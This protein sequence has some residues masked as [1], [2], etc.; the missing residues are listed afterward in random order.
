MTALAASGSGCSPAASATLNSNLREVVGAQALHSAIDVASTMPTGT[1]P[2]NGSRWSVLLSS[3]TPSP[4]LSSQPWKGVNNTNVTDT[5]SA[6]LHSCDGT[7]LW[8]LSLGVASETSNTSESSNVVSDSP[9]PSESE[10]CQR[11]GSDLDEFNLLAGYAYLRLH[12]H[13]GTPVR[14]CDKVSASVSSYLLLQASR[15]RFT[16][17]LLVPVPMSKVPVGCS[18]VGN[19]PTMALLQTSSGDIVCDPHIVTFVTAAVMLALQPTS[20]CPGV[21]VGM[22]GDSWLGEPGREWR[23]SGADGVVTCVTNYVR[24]PALLC[25]TVSMA[26]SSSCTTPV[27][28]RSLSCSRI[29]LPGKTLGQFAPCSGCSVHVETANKRRSRHEHNEMVHNVEATGASSS[30]TLNTLIG[31]ITISALAANLSVNESYLS[32]VRTVRITRGKITG[33]DCSELRHSRHSLC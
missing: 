5:G 15:Y 13:D 4:A 19:C 2:T 12:W 21:A 32:A 23:G 30:L 6:A 28:I 24:N 18:Y 1:K 31:S 8:R 33:S 22:L 20:P 26:Y 16:E 7:L 29:A 9:R 14:L 10:S 3:L 17:K 11:T 27:E 25:A